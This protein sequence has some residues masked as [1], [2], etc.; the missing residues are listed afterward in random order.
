MQINLPVVF[1]YTKVISYNGIK[2]MARL[3]E[4]C[5]FAFGS[6]LHW[7]YE[8]DRLTLLSHGPEDRCYYAN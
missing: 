8:S 4:D 7:G 1:D 2:I 6:G 5:E 3:D